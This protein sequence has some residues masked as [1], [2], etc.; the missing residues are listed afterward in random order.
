[1]VPQMPLTQWTPTA[2]TGSSMWSLR[3]STST[4]TTTM[5]PE[6]MPTMAAPSP[7]SASQPAVMPTRPASE[8][9]R[10]IETSGLPFLIQV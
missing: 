7:S 9:F 6:T 5:M 1:M 3:S 10:H 4:A 2:P 8:A